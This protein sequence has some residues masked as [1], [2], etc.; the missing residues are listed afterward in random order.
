MQQPYLTNLSVVLSAPVQVWSAFDGQVDGLAPQRVAEGVYCGDSRVLSQLLLSSPSHEL[1]HVA[2]HE[3]GGS[4]ARFQYV[5]RTHD[6][7][8]DPAVVLDRHREV[9]RD[10][11]R[12]RLVLS[13]ASMREV[14]VRLQLFLQPDATTMP[15]IKS[16]QQ[17]APVTPEQGEDGT[18]RFHW[19][20]GSTTA[21]LHTAAEVEAFDGGW[22]LTWTLLL[23]ARGRVEAGLELE[24]A[25]QAAP[26]CATT[27]PLLRPP[28]TDGTNPALDRLLQTS[29]ADINGLRMA[30]RNNPS[31]AFLAAGSPWYFT[32][33]GRDSLI[34]ARNLVQ[35]D[36]T[37]AVGTLRVLAELQ[38]ST[39]DVEQAQQPGKI[40]HEVRQEP[41][42]MALTHGPVTGVDGEVE[43]PPEHQMRLPPLYYGT[44]D[45][46]PLWIMLFDEADQAGMYAEEVRALLPHLRRAL[47]WMRDFG[48]SDGDGFLEYRDESGHGLANQGWKDSGDS[49]RFRDGHLAAGSVALAEVQG[50]AHAAALGGARLLESYE[51]DTETANFWRDWAA[52]LAERFRRHFW[53]SDELGPYP[54]LALDGATD[55]Q[56]NK[57]QVD[58]VASNMGH[59]LGTGIL[60]E[61]E[62]E[63]VVNRL[64]HPSMF[65]GYGIRTMSSTNGGY[66]PLGYHVGSVWAHDTAFI[67]DAMLR[68]G[69]QEQA[70]RLAR[71][72]LQA[73]EGYGFRLPELFGGLGSD[74]V[75]PPQPYPA[76]C[77]P[78]AWAATS[79][80]VVARALG[81][82]PG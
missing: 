64:M 68:T 21:T 55:E 24:L 20:D 50:Y 22:L 78:Q 32:L 1:E 60:D 38:G 57:L 61:T 80:V 40:L 59:L 3:P 8:V 27:A 65:S 71:G 26:F 18:H 46:T 82:L 73:A 45:A 47:D 62:T 30:P 19:R 67:L 12:E 9:D 70:A 35:H 36:V 52:Q 15:S 5:V 31:R 43:A 77:R 48:D 49:I 23:P 29:F 28:H 37:T 6:L 58:G 79:A 81:A 74:E 4:S 17:A 16:G 14:E 42:E 10:G 51:G 7:G 66:W 53:A 34:S 2:S 56:G 54:V 41:L 25:D 11:L 69:H 75:F 44:V 39:I 13:T 33:F 63:I 76:S 72:L